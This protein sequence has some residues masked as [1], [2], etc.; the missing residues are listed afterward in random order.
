MNFPCLVNECTNHTV[1]GECEQPSGRGKLL[2]AG[3]EGVITQR[4][5]C[6]CITNFI[7]VVVVETGG[8]RRAG[9]VG[10]YNGQMC[11][12]CCYCCCQFH[13][14][15]CCCHRCHVLACL[16]ISNN[17]NNIRLILYNKKFAAIQHQQQQQCISQCN[18]LLHIYIIVVLFVVDSFYTHTHTIVVGIA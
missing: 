12:C 2:G 8:A 11:V 10:G 9:H 4:S 16:A 5:V 15:C 13:C 1:G 14:Y 6:V 18:A 7:V 17:D 3:H